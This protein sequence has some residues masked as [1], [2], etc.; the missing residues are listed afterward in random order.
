MTLE[1]TDSP[2]C[3]LALRSTASPGSPNMLQLEG[4]RATFSAIDSGAVVMVVDPQGTVGRVGHVLRVRSALDTTTLYFDRVHAFATRVATR[5]L[6]LSVPVAPVVRVRVEDVS[7]ALG[8]DGG[9]TL[10]ALPIVDD[11]NY[12]RE[13]L[14]LAT[15][16]DLLGPAGG[17]DEYVIDMSVR[18]RYLVGKL[19]PRTPSGQDEVRIEPD[20]AGS[21]EAEAL[22]DEQKA[23]THEPGA[24]FNRASG[25]VE[26]EE[27]AVDEIDTTNNQ[28][29]VPSSLGLTLCVGRDVRRIDITARWGRYVRV[30][31]DEHEHTRLRKNRET[32]EKE[33]VK[34]KVWRRIPCGG[35]AT[36]TL[37]E[38]RISPLTPDEREPE[39]RLQ[40]TVRTNANGERLVTL[41]L[42]NGQMEP[43][44]NKDSAWLFQPEIV[45]RCE[46]G[47][48]ERSVFRRRPTNDVVVDDPERDHLSLIYRRRVEFAVGHGVAV[49]AETALDDVS[50]A[51]EVRTEVIP[52]YEV[53]VT[54][55]PGLE[56]ADR[57]PMRAMVERGWLDMR[58][59]AEM[60]AAEL[61]NALGTLVDDYAAWIDEQS[62]RVGGEIVGHDG[63]GHQALDRCRTTLGRL[64]AGME[65]LLRDG[66]ALRAFRFANQ[67]MALQRVHAI[68][69]LKRRRNETIDLA[70]VDIRENRSW[71]PFQLAFLLLSLPSLSDPRHVDRT[72]PSEAFADL[73]WFPTGGGKTEAYLGVAAFAMGIRRLQGVVADLDGTRGLAVI[74]RYT[75]RL[76]TLQ[77]F[78][79]AAT[80]LCARET[81]RWGMRR[82]GVSSPLPWVCG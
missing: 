22:E 69:A 15:R 66:N 29:L 34:V 65:V 44:T 76:L 20:A 48:E 25:R 21:D 57:P 23:P 70:Q 18:D 41:F 13:L 49:H 42:V 2:A 47:A 75:L 52:R 30:P 27:D 11:A 71:R 1:K 78:Q 37:A 72:S 3:W 54:E 56:P 63:P 28:S 5:D 50:R 77:Q 17:P 31:K 32:G 46:S 40:G 81:F 74:M 33:P 4:G 39:V 19:A 6:G 7:A 55:T 58:V 59:L 10:D 38:G 79:R 61:G 26:P 16:D 45:V 12:V 82:T 51:V 68:F 14:E 53:S 36:L 80:L 43:A 24:E 9:P 62:A 64:R 73:L 60:D 67:A 35:T 8:R